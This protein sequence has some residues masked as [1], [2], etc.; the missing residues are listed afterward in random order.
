MQEEDNGKSQNYWVSVSW[1]NGKF[2]PPTRVLHLEHSS[3]LAIGDMPL[4]RELQS[5]KL[6]LGF[7]GIELMTIDCSFSIWH[8]YRIILRSQNRKFKFLNAPSID[9]FSA[10]SSK[11]SLRKIPCKVNGRENFR[12]KIKAGFYR[13]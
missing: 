6:W 5:R 12:F 10:S 13:F 2:W 11:K 7:Q 8:A 1:A 9:F 3:H 4:K